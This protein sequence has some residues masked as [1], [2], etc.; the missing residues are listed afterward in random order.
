MSSLFKTK[1]FANI[2][3]IGDHESKKADLL[4]FVLAV[5]T[6]ESAKSFALDNIARPTPD[7]T[8]SSPRYDVECLG[9]VRLTMVDVPELSSDAVPAELQTVEQAI[10]DLDLI[11][12]FIVVADCT[13]KELGH[14]IEDAL[15]AVSL[16]FPRPVRKNIFYI[17]TSQDP[18]KTTIGHTQELPSEAKSQVIGTISNM[19]L[20]RDLFK[21]QYKSSGPERQEVLL[22]DFER[23]FTKGAGILEELFRHVDRCPRQ[24]KNMNHV[25]RLAAT[26]ESKLYAILILE[27]EPRLEDVGVIDRL[28]DE[29][30]LIA[31]SPDFLTHL[32]M[33]LD[34]LRTNMVGRAILNLTTTLPAF[35][36]FFKGSKNA[37]ICW[38]PGGT[39][40]SLYRLSDITE[41]WSAL[42]GTGFARID[43]ILPVP[44]NNRRAYFFCADKYVLIEFELGPFLLG[45]L[46]TGSR[47]VVSVT[48]ISTGWPSI[49]KAGFDRIDA[50]LIVP[51]RSNEAY[52]FSKSQYCRIRFT[53]GIANDELLDGPKDI[54]D[55]WGVMDFDEIEGI[56]PRPGKEQ[57]AYV[58]CE[59]Q[60]VQIRVNVGDRDELITGRRD[61][62]EWWPS[63][64]ATGFY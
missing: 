6:G 35:T 18:T 46:I 19:V 64:K 39:N 20:L 33:V 44:N 27:R 16:A 24:A 50:A 62:I 12:A 53:P 7:N 25:Y 10:D 49:A 40:E 15:Q 57:N 63:L 1:E 26:I 17:F 55:Y 2:V 5:L 45:E 23:H 59:D 51:G 60:Y 58:F 56:I 3:L 28:V 37:I 29:Y 54:A 13:K 61:V 22:H 11:D 41:T 43:A 4:P 21:K 34:L 32:E 9:R 36:C 52:I 8:K 31:T 48:K 30:C 47:L 42:K 38:T 14:G